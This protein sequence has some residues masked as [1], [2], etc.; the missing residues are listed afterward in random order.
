MYRSGKRILNQNQVSE[1]ALV[2]PCDTRWNSYFYMLECVQKNKGAISVTQLD[3]S[4]EVELGSRQQLNPDDWEK[5]TAL[6][7]HVL[8]S[9]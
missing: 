3:E 9:F 5:I 1:N 2:T 8:N 6:L 7:T 4:L